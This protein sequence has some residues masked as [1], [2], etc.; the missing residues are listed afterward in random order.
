MELPEINSA[1]VVRVE[2]LKRG[3]CLLLDLGI[4][5][6]RAIFVQRISQN[7]MDFV[8]TDVVI[9]VCVKHTPE[10][11]RLV[12]GLHQLNGRHG[13]QSEECAGKFHC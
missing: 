1:I 11:F 4:G 6:L 8:T 12:A 2:M 3:S 10:L 7:A 9:R 5:K 13:G